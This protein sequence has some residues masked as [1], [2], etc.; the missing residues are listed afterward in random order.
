MKMILVFLVM[1]IQSSGALA[2]AEELNKQVVIEFFEKYG[3][4]PSFVGL[5]HPDVK[6]W[7]PETLSFG[8]EFQSR[9]EYF[10]MLSTVFVG[11]AEPL[12]L[13]IKSMVAQGNKVSVEVES[14]ATH[15]CGE[16]EP[17]HYNNKYHFLITLENGKFV[18]VKEYNDTK[19]LSDLYS[20]I[21]SDSCKTKLQK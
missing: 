20:L 9:Q 7:V 12:E 18:R 1:F 14:N 10:T 8:K 21:Q 16:P 4:D 5:V 17:F 3:K 6:W 19:H 13:D 15:K 11:F 2:S